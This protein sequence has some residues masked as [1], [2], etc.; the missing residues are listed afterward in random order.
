MSLFRI[1]SPDTSRIIHKNQKEDLVTM[2]NVVMRSF[3]TLITNHAQIKRLKYWV[4][5]MCNFEI[6]RWNSNFICFYPSH[7]QPSP[8][9]E[10]TLQ[11]KKFTRK[12]MSEYPSNIHHP[13]PAAEPTT[14]PFLG[15]RDLPFDKIFCPRETPLIL[16]RAKQLIQW[17]IADD[18]P[19][20][21]HWSTLKCPL[22]RSSARTQAQS[23]IYAK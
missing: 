3:F 16:K 20:S 14:L 19:S 21:D 15:S 9:I 10:S 1:N 5:G 17:P 7:H 6:S 2:K 11:S 12:Y 4:F 18:H 23:F 13:Y 22:S 8:N